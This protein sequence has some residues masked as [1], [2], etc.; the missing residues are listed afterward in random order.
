[1]VL[2]VYY[3]EDSIQRSVLRLHDFLGRGFPFTYRITIAD[4]GSTDDTWAV[5]RHLAA[6]VQATANACSRSL[7]RSP[8]SSMP[9]E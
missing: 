6:A 1:V 8:A 9:T 2:P 7:I 5:A 3:E 4:N